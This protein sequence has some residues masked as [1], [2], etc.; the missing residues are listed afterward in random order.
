MLCM[1]LRKKN[2]EVFPIHHLTIGFYNRGSKCL[3]RG[4]N[5]VLITFRP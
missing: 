2:I 3:L 4:T 1:Y 5:W